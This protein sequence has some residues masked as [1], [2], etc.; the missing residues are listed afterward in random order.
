[1][2]HDPHTKAATPYRYHPRSDVAS[3]KLAR[4]V[5]EDLYATIPGLRSRAAR[6]EAA[7]GVT[8]RYSFENSEKEKALDLAV[9]IPATPPLLLTDGEMPE[10]KSLARLFIGI[11][12]KAAM[13]KHVGAKPRLWDELASSHQIVHAGDQQAIACGITVVNIAERFASPTRNLIPGQPLVWTNHNQPHAAE[14]LLA[15]LRRLPIRSEI[16][17][18]GFDAY[19][20]IVVNCDNVGPCTVCT[21]PPAPQPGDRDEYGAFIGRVASLFARRFP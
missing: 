1:V 8:L 6:G 11:E 2:H 4:L 17:Q 9:G 5:L 20:N 21:T 13:T 16:G 19:C 14:D 7:Y 12:A 10:V 3:K 18:V 15:F